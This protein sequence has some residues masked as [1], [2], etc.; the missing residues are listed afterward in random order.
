MDHVI[1]TC[2]AKNPDDRWQTAH[3]L[4]LQLEWVQAV[5][6][7]S[8]VS[9]PIVKQ[10]RRMTALAWGLAAALAIGF[11]LATVA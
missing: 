7:Q 9:L 8:G 6:S 2:L 3:D 10:K 5:G 4:K 1:A 11:A